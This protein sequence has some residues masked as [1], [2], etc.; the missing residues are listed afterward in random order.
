MESQ[1]KSVWE[2]D[3]EKCREILSAIEQEMKSLRPRIVISVHEPGT[4]D[5]NLCMV[6]CGQWY[7]SQTIGMLKTEL[8]RSLVSQP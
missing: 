7:L 4:E 3:N 6:T 5:Q 1:E 8:M 2:T